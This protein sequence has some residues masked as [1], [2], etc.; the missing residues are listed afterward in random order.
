V[1]EGEEIQT[2][3]TETADMTGGMVMKDLIDHH[4]SAP[5]LLNVLRVACKRLPSYLLTNPKPRR[6]LQPS[7]IY[8]Q[9]NK[10]TTTHI[11]QLSVGLT[12]TRSKALVPSSC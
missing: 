1:F 8:N 9:N 11:L 12:A 10:T 3:M 7:Y 2:N 4:P 5:D 6:S